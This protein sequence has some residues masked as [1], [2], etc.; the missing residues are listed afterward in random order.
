VPGH[1]LAVL[2]HLVGFVPV[3]PLVLHATN[4]LFKFQS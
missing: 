2:L 3:L 1:R 4:T